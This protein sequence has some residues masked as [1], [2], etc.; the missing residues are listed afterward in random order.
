MTADSLKCWESWRVG[1]G[2]SKK[3]LFSIVKPGGLLESPL[4]GT[5]DV[6][7]LCIWFI[8]TMAIAFAKARCSLLLFL[9]MLPRK[10]H[11]GEA[12]LLKTRWGST[13]RIIFRSYQILKGLQWYNI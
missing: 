8:V 5:R 13:N 6:K 1:K 4:L 7:C 11:F 3:V 10:G 2:N 12:Q 9:S